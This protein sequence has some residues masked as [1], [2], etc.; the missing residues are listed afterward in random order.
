MQFAH[1]FGHL[2]VNGIFILVGPFRIAGNE[3]EAV[4]VTGKIG[5]GKFLLCTCLQIVETESG[6]VGNEDVL[7]KLLLRNTGE[8]VQGLLIG[9]VQILAPGLMFDDEHAF[10]KEVNG[11]GFIA[12]LPDGRFKGSDAPA[13]NAEDIEELVPESLGL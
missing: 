4:D 9:L 10:Q 1:L 11:T 6:E 8:I 3:A 5:E 12:Q 2:D 13:G 7:G